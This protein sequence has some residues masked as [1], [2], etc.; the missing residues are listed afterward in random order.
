MCVC[1][2]VR[3]CVLQ[4]VVYMHTVLLLSLICDSHFFELVRFDFVIDSNL[5]VWLMEVSV[6]CVNE[7]ASLV[8]FCII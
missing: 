2:C 5:K 6:S 1:V 7:F 8:I 3:A 4:C